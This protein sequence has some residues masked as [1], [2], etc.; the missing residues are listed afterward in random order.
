MFKNVV[1]INEKGYFIKDNYPRTKTKGIYI[2]G[3]AVDKELRQLT[4]AV[5]DGSLAATIAIKE[6]KGE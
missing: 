4:T 2:A 5:G 1:D 3:D 6:M